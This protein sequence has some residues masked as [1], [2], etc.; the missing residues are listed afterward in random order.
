M[1]AIKVA[2]SL[3]PARRGLLGSVCVPGRRLCLPLLLRRLGY[4]KNWRVSTNTSQT[5]TWTGEVSRGGVVESE[6]WR[7]FKNEDCVG[8]GGFALTT[9][10]S[11]SRLLEPHP[12]GWRLPRRRFGCYQGW[13][14]P[15]NT[16]QTPT[17]TGEVSRGGVV[18]SEEWRWLKTR[19]KSLNGRVRTYFKNFNVTFTRT[20]SAR[21]AAPAQLIWFVERLEGSPDTPQT[22]TRTGEVSRGGV[23]ESEKWRWVKTEECVGTGDTAQTPRGL[24]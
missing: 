11:T 12:R 15:P 19:C 13:K 18:E 2:L 20:A 9:I 8:T 1:F 17:R 22:P 5:H 24:E 6:K 16:P 7:W 4:I 14:D 3:A 10:S 23:V 21:L